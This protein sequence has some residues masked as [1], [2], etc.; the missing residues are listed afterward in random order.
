MYVIVDGDNKILRIGHVP[1]FGNKV[2]LLACFY[3]ETDALETLYEVETAL[4][5][6]GHRITNTGDTFDVIP[7]ATLKIHGERKANMKVL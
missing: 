3:T 1:L 4:G 6:K 2:E 5:L 7:M